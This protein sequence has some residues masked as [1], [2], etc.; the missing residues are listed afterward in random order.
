[1][2]KPRRE[3]LRATFDQ[4]AGLYDR[5]RPGYP[6]DLVAELARLAGIAAGS[7]V[8]EVGCGT[9]QLTVPLAER[10]C[11]IVAL[12]IGPHLAARARRNLARHPAAC[13]IVA[14][15]EDWSLPALPFDAVVSATA[16]HWLD[17]AV[18]VN[19][20]ADAL[21]PGGALATIATHH[22]AGGDEQFFVEAQGCYARWDPSAPPAGLRLPRAADIAPDSEELDRSGRFGPATFRRYEWENAYSAV[23]YRE[24]LLTYSGHRALAPE[25]LKGLLDCIARL[26]DRRYNGK[27]TQ[28]Y[29]SELRVANR[30]AGDRAVS[31]ATATPGSSGL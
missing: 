25:A 29:L 11:E 2:D 19:K 9:G 26:I 18:R 27:I 7:R 1:M 22:V 15:F 8:L 6:A 10:G 20:A 17:P 31:P 23:A 24:L 14:A 21:R 3:Q 4:A 13:V 28:R 5:A 12:D 30:L 16:F